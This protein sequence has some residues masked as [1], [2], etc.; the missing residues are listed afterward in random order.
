METGTYIYN[1][2]ADG[3]PWHIL[4]GHMEIHF[5]FSLQTYGLTHKGSSMM[6]SPQPYKVP[7]HHD[8]LFVSH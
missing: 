4:P 6:E 7:G 1:T 8:P 5:I 3:K 2:N